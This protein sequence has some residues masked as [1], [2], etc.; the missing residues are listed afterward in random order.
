MGTEDAKGTL[1]KILVNKELYGQTGI[2]A[3]YKRVLGELTINFSLLHF[4][5]DLRVSHLAEKL[6]ASVSFTVPE[7]YREKFKDLVA[8]TRKQQKSEMTFSIAFGLSKM[9]NRFYASAESMAI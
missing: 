3:A 9:V 4:N 1:K 8:K 7:P 6:I 5:L 2:E